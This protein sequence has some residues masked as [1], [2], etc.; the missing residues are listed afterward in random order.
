MRKVVSQCRPRR[1]RRHRPAVATLAAGRELGHTPQSVSASAAIAAWFM[2]ASP[3]AHSSVR[4]SS[5]PLAA[6]RP[7]ENA[8]RMIFLLSG[9]AVA[10]WAS[11]VPSAKAA[12]GVN[13]AQLG[14]VLLCLGIGSILAMPVGGALATRFGCRAVLGIS[15]LVLCGCLPVLA[16]VSSVAALAATLFVFGAMLGTFDCVMNIQAVIVERDSNRPLMSGFHGFYSLGGLLGAA[17]TSSIMELGVSPLPSVTMIGAL[18]LLLML[19]SWRHMLP[20]S[21]PSEGGPAFALPR[22]IVL[23]L[24][25]LCFTVFLVEGSMMDWSAVFL[26]ER[27]G[28]SL[29]Q[30][31]YGFAAF[32]LAMTFGRL[33]GDRIVARAGRQRVVMVG[34][35]LAVLGIL[36]A[37]WGASWPLALVGYALVGL[38]SSNI[39]P[40][41]FTAVGRQTSMPQSVALPAMTTMGYAGVLAG[42]RHRLHCSPVPAWRG[43]RAG[44]GDDGRGGHQR[45]V[46]EGLIRGG[47]PASKCPAGCRHSRTVAAVDEQPF[48]A[49]MSGQPGGGG[50][51]SA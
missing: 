27:H 30:A 23:F 6:G 32:S 17:A 47:G 26:T 4:S 21:N 40:V 1:G 45:E 38:G 19:A 12:T 37:T 25:V 13:E 42:R 48:S 44:G 33:T 5:H 10:A 28:M 36:L 7:Y 18:G 16:V 43:V 41:L 22:G 31:G 35:T 24:G 51:I 29:A 11:L 2:N 20:W 34:G 49:G 39:V 8:T 9:L 50:A 46:P 15:G 14:L 3:P